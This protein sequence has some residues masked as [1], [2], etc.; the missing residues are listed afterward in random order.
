MYV[1]FSDPAS[2]VLGSRPGYSI[3]AHPYLGL[4]ILFQKFQVSVHLIFSSFS[5]HC[6][7]LFSLSLSLLIIL[8][9][10]H[11]QGLSLDV[12][13]SASITLAIVGVY[14]NSYSNVD[15][16]GCDISKVCSFYVATLSKA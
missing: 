13:L 14:L 5:L 12:S 15:K 10:C 8:S 7:S 2:K 6:L 9:F 1:C 11:N 4:V 3:T 16:Q